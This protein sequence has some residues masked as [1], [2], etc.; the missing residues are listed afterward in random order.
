MGI[1][2]MCQRL[3]IT[4]TRYNFASPYL[5]REMDHNK[6]CTG[7]NKYSRLKTRRVLIGKIPLGSGYPIRIQSMTNTSTSN[8]EAT[9][10]QCIRIAGAGADFVRITVPSVKDTEYLKQIRDGLAKKGYYFPLIADIHFNPQVAEIAASMVEK[11]R[12]NPGNYANRNKS[13][14]AG[15]TD[16]E[17]RMALLR[18]REKFVTL[19]RICK[20]HHTAIRIGVNHGSLSERI[21]HRYGDTPAGMAESAMEFLRICIEES[22][23]NVVVSMKSSNTIIMVQ[24]TRLLVHKMMG[25]NMVFPLHLGVTEAGEG[26]DGRIKSATGIGAL[27]A[28]GI[29]DTIR[30]SLTEEPENEVPVA[31]KLV[32]NFTDKERNKSGKPSFPSSP[33]NPFEYT[34]R[35]T[36]PVQNIGGQ[37]LPVVVCEFA[38]NHVSPNDLVQIGWVYDKSN[39]KWKFT[40]QSADLLYIKKYHDG[41]T[42]PRDK[43]IIIDY[44]SWSSITNASGQ[45]Y[46]LLTSREYQEIAEDIAAPH[47]VRV[48]YIDLNPELITRLK[49]DHAAI[50]ILEADNETGFHGQRGLVFELMNRNCNV[51]VI[52]RRTFSEREIE[53]FQLKSAAD[54]G[55]L[56]I[57]GLGDG[58]WLSNDK[59]IGA[60][61]I[62]STAFGILQASRSR[63]SRVE[64]ISCPSCGRTNFDIMEVSA[65]IREKT[66]H[67][68]GLKIGIMGCIVNG[69]G[70]MADADYGYVGAARGKI[71]LYKAKQVVKR[72]IPEKDAV[73]ELISLI[74]KNG[75]WVNP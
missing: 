74:K 47:F 22:F 23:D 61:K 7:L 34:R 20:K 21:I 13:V 62:C 52:I 42:L 44:A 46:P 40:D 67:L 12:I 24:S 68:K 33:V 39:D 63:I 41:I 32:K 69:I 66:S 36:S 15:Y 64:Y 43:G 60:E 10:G 59:E 72:N 71:A 51:P 25:E 5:I 8:I 2:F 55:G 57:D 11:V 37:H 16:E 56:F 3:V 48:T 70:E 14:K 28:D 31:I 19:I 49:K 75:D 38:Q 50:L 29:G 65:K 6:Y 35:R 73:D 17:Y 54:L 27:L 58:I 4:F 30:V 1:F 53:N 26:E 45:F 9:I 18:I